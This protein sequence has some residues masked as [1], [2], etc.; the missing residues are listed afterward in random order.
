MSIICSN[1]NKQLNDG[2]KFCY[3]C[4]G[5]V[6]GSSKTGSN[7]TSS[8]GYAYRAPH[9]KIP[10]EFAGMVIDSDESLIDCLQDGVVKNV[11]AGGGLATTK[12]FFTDQRFYAEARQFTFKKGLCTDIIVANLSDISGTQISHRNPIGSLLM[13]GLVFL[14]SILLAAISGGAELFLTGLFLVILLVV[15]FLLKKG[16]CLTISYPG[17]TV[18]I[19]VKMYSYDRVTEFHKKLRA[20]LKNR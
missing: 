4:G 8:G 10:P 18:D 14:L 6:T 17:N 13:A 5:M 16:T 20:S 1:C 2:T 9:R 3:Y 12:V 7:V 15:N 11:V 19:S